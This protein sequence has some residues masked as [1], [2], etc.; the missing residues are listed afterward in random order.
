[1][2]DSPLSLHELIMMSQEADLKKAEEDCLRA[3]SEREEVNAKA[4]KPTEIG[5]NKL[6]QMLYGDVLPEPVT[7]AP[8][9][10]QSKENKNERPVQ[11]FP[12]PP[13]GR[14]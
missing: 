4:R 12:P 11:A 2:S 1:M 13:T 10:A 6:I 3:R 14:R 9:P 8:R 5:Y 7:A